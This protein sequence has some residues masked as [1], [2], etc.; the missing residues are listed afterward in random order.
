M[1]DPSGSAASAQA[2]IPL[3]LPEFNGKT[4]RL[5][6][7]LDEIA[8]VRPGDDLL[9]RGLYVDLPAYGG[10]L[11]RVTRETNPSRRRSGNGSGNGTRASQ[12]SGASSSRA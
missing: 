9:T 3:A 12:P 4:V 11:F 10:H 7:Q 1:P 8:Y 5:D 6:D 2:Y